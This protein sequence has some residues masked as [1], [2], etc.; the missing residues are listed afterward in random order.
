M[1][2]W[3]RLMWRCLQD[4][5]GV[6]VSFASLRFSCCAREDVS[7]LSFDNPTL[8]SLRRSKPF[9]S[10]TEDEFEV[11]TFFLPA[12]TSTSLDAEALSESFGE[13]ISLLAGLSLSI[14]AGLR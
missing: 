7:S 14:L 12:L 10:T 5:G 6:T 11:P 13:I 2:Q 1:L 8:D 3:F 4:T 9:S